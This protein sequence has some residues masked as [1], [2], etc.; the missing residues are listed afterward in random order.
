M[1]K[2]YGKLNDVPYI[3]KD[4]SNLKATLKHDTNHHDMQ[5]MLAVFDQMRSE[6]KDFFRKLKL[7]KDNR[8]ENIFWMDGPARRAYKAGYNDCISFDTTYLTNKYKM[9]CDPFIGIN[10]HGQSIQL[11]CGFLIQELSSNFVWLFKM[12]KLAM[13]DIPLMRGE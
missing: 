10:N 2:F 6:D 8:F 1:S 5:D 12:F 13:G 7:D 4:V 11:G 3:E 9:P